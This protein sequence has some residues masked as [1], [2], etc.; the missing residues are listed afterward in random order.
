MCGRTI[1]EHGVVLHV[2]HKVPRDLGGKTE[3]ENLWAICS[4]CNEGKKN[5]FKSLAAPEMMRAMNHKSVHMRLGEALKAAK[6]EPV[7]AEILYV[8]ANQDDWKKRVRELRYLGWDIA[9]HNEKN[10][11]GRVVSFYQLVSHNP[12]PADPTGDIRRYERDRAT[13]NKEG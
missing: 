11:S 3:L 10:A 4:T 6:G 12:W 1:E 2:D 8:I 7:S 5:H 13:K 9:T